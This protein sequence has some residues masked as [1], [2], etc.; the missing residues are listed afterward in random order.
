MVIL[1][2]LENCRS[3]LIL[4]S[5]FSILKSRVWVLT[6]FQKGSTLYA[7]RTS[8]S[9]RNMFQRKVL[10][11]LLK[12]IVTWESKFTICKFSFSKV[13]ALKHH[14]NQGTRDS[15]RTQKRRVSWTSIRWISTCLPLGESSPRG[16]VLIA[17]DCPTPSFKQG[18][19]LPFPRGPFKTKEVKVKKFPPIVSKRRKISF[20]EWSS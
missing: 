5:N 19:A 8:T 16:K 6:F 12:I 4:L 14:L 9:K 20:R 18:R 2:Q 10:R 11:I 17:R 13:R 7:K 15:K 3:R 1:I